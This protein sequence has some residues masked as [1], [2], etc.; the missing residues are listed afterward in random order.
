MNQERQAQAADDMADIYNAKFGIDPDDPQQMYRD[1]E[2]VLVKNISKLKLEYPWYGPLKILSRTPFGAYKLAWPDG[3]VKLDLVHKDRLK[4]AHLAGATTPSR[5]WYKTKNDRDE[6]TIP[7]EEIRGA[8]E[9]GPQ[10]DPNVIE[11]PHQTSLRG[12][13]STQPRAALAPAPPPRPPKAPARTISRIDAAGAAWIS[14]GE[15]VLNRGN[16][17]SNTMARDVMV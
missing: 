3:K 6:L 4:R 2:W 10:S 14:R 17:S 11:Q 16:L 5:A 9:E 13:K 7:M 12:D 1:G 8:D 15:V